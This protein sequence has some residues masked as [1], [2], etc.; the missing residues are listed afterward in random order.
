MGNCCE[1]EQINVTVETHSCWEM[2]ACWEFFYKRQKRRWR[3]WWLHITYHPNKAFYFSSSYLVSPKKHI[4]RQ[5]AQL[6]SFFWGGISQPKLFNALT[7]IM[8]DHMLWPCQTTGLNYISRVIMIFLLLNNSLIFHV[9][10]QYFWYKTTISFHGEK[11][12]KCQLQS[13]KW[14]SLDFH[15]CDLNAQLWN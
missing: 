13:W 3:A 12:M 8:F 14:I 10:S 15:D 7:K 11:K 2:K 9:L 4:C 1:I 5:F 6:V